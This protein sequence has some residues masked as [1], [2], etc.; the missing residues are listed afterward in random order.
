MPNTD[1]TRPAYGTIIPPA[2]LQALKHALG[3]KQGVIEV[4]DPSLSKALVDIKDAINYPT[5]AVIGKKTILR[6]LAAGR[7]A[8]LL[9]RPTR[10]ISLAIA[11]FMAGPLCLSLAPV[12]SLGFDQ[13]FALLNEYGR[14][15]EVRQTPKGAMA[16]LH[17]NPESPPHA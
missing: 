7:L 16:V 10:G 6:Q 1:A 5:D 12:A 15:L 2:A 13:L 11:G 8:M 4:G 17:R 9:A 3:V 14:P